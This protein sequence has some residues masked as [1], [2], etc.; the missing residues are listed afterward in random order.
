MKGRVSVAFHPT[1][2]IL[3]AGT[4]AIDNKYIMLLDMSNRNNN[5]VNKTYKIHDLLL[6]SKME[7]LAISFS[8]VVFRN[9]DNSTPIVYVA[10]VGKNTDKPIQQV[11]EIN[12]YQERYTVGPSYKLDSILIKDKDPPTSTSTSAFLCGVSFRTF[13]SVYDKEYKL[14]MA[15]IDSTNNTSFYSLNFGG[16]N[17]RDNFSK[18]C[19][20]SSFNDILGFKHNPLPTPR[21]IA[22]NGPFFAMP[23]SE[24]DIMLFKFNVIETKEDGES[25]KN[26]MYSTVM[27]SLRC[28]MYLLL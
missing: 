8:P 12:T 11:Y 6:E 19:D 5:Y 10:C 14:I 24:S 21:G 28:C 15:V 27:Q 18:L 23:S 16:T 3:V 13:K 9:K 20:F 1:K 2:H 22:F 26:D 25:Y 4:S 7:V 17:N